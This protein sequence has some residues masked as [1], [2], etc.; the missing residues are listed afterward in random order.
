MML[1]MAMIF[2]SRMDPTE[3]MRTKVEDVYENVNPDQGTPGEEV[4]AAS[5]NVVVDA[6][7]VAPAV[8]DSGDMEQPPATPRTPATV[9]LRRSHRRVGNQELRGL[10]IDPEV[11]KSLC[12]ANDEA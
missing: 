10:G 1:L 8:E 6:A 5:Q 11:V 7:P 4:A 3:K 2:F 12:T 9:T